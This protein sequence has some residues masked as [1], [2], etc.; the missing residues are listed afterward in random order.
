MKMP[1]HMG[2]QKRTTKNLKIIDVRSDENLL[3]IEGSIPGTRGGLVA[4][5]NRAADFESRDE[6][7]PKKEEPQKEF[8]PSEDAAAAENTQES[9][10]KE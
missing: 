9:Q 3:F 10:E 2:V 1:G 5:Y 8:E 4:I 6:L 7:K